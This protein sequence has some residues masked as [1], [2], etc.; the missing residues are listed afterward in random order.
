MDFLDPLDPMFVVLW[1]EFL[2]PD[3]EYECPNCGGRFGGNNVTWS[4]A[5]ALFIYECPDC[6]HV[7]PIA[8]P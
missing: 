5:D 4:D 2:D 7:G 1:D 6:G 3:A 8:D